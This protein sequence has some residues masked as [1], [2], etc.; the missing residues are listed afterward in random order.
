MREFA[1]LYAELTDTMSSKRKLEALQAYFSSAAPEN[2]AWAVYFLA[3]GKPR[4]IVPGKLLRV[5]A[6]QYA[7]LDD[8]LFDASYDVVGDLAETI[9]LILPPPQQRSDVG[10]AQWI[11][12]RLSPLRGAAPEVMR[13]ALFRFWNELGTAE[14]F[15]LV[16][17]IS[18]SFRAGVS[19]LL[20]TRAL[21]VLANVDSKVIAQRLMGWLEGCASPTASHFLQLISP[22]SIK[23]EPAP[24]HGLAGGQPYPFLFAHSLQGE[25]EALGKLEHWQVEWKYDGVRA[26]LV[27]RDGRNWLWSRDEEL[28][29]ERFPELASLQLPAGV[30]LDGEILI[31]HAGEAP[32]APGSSGSSGF[33]GSFAEL[34]K[35]SARKSVSSKLQIALPAVLLACDVLEI[36]GFDVRHQPLQQRRRLLETLVQQVNAPQ[37]QLAPVVVA[38]DWQQLAALRQQSRLRGVEGLMLKA[39]DATYG[40]GRTAGA[41]WKWNIE[42]YTIDAVLIYASRRAGLDSDYTFAVWDRDLEPDLTSDSNPDLNGASARKLVPFAKATSGLSDADIVQVD[43]VIRSTTIEKFGPVRSVTPSLVFQIG[44]DGIALSSRHKAGIVVRLPRIV[45][46]RADKSIDEADTLDALKALL[47]A[48]A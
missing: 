15:L 5:Y 10:L 20:L 26:Q 22:Q 13:A 38:G 28:I 31:W 7:G 42:P 2:A 12:Q 43:K 16:K 17:L 40:V 6:A 35:R 27:S 24:G 32:A 1:R 9:A 18:S 36:D 46:L 47:L 3:G 39:C 4:Q 25:P 23:S 41:W 8:W 37:L 33:P 11:E 34:Q 14:R 19:T 48:P 29:T 30:V 44:F 21:G 45:R